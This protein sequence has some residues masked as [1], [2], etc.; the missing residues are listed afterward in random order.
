[1]STNANFPEYFTPAYVHAWNGNAMAL[2]KLLEK[3]LDPNHT[4]ASNP[5]ITLPTLLHIAA[6]RG[7]RVVVQLLRKHGANIDAVDDQGNT[8]LMSAITSPRGKR[9]VPTFLTEFDGKIAD[10][11]VANHLGYT[12]IFIAA[13]DNETQFVRLLLK[14]GARPTVQTYMGE[15][16][17]TVANE[18]EIKKLLA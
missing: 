18:Y 12:P 5:A 15:T 2:S 14:A 8:P 17:V 10:P 6:E 3:G 16:A 13:R 7:K 9:L 1:M 4:P 11:N